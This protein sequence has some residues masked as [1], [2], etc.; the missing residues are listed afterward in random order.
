MF[1]RK[2]KTKNK[3]RVWLWSHLATHMGGEITPGSELPFSGCEQREQ[4][5]ELGN[6]ASATCKYSGGG[7]QRPAGTDTRE[8]WKPNG[9]PWG[10]GDQVHATRNLELYTI[11]YNHFI[12]FGIIIDLSI[13]IILAC[14]L[15]FLSIFSFW[16]KCF[17]FSSLNFPVL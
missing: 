6:Q 9:K 7:Y 17:K 3:Q 13:I 16:W 11:W 14:L 12:D 8:D 2:W 10:L 4:G 15:S 1:Q 5:N